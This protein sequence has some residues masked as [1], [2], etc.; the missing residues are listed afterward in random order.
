MG[1]E[2]VNEHEIALQFDGARCN[3]QSLDIFTP[4]FIPFDISL[5]VDAAVG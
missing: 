4:F 5:L 3:M 1:L 2:M